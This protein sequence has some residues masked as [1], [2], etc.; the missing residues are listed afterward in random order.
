[1][2]SKLFYYVVLL[3]MI[4][5]LPVFS[6][7]SNAQLVA[8]WSLDG[9][10]LDFS[11]NGN[12][13]SGSNGS[14]VTGRYGFSYS[15][16]GSNSLIMVPDSS[17]LSAPGNLTI[18]AW[19]FVDGPPTPSNNYNVIVSKWGPGGTSDDE[20]FFIV[21]GDTDGHKL[22]AGINGSGGNLFEMSNIIVP[23]GEWKFVA[24][25]LDTST[26][27]LS[28][29]MGD[30]SGITDSYSV[31]TPV[32]ADYD[33][34]QPLY[35]GFLDAS[36]SHPD[37]YFRGK[38]DEVR[39]YNGALSLTELSKIAQQ[40][41]D[42]K[43]IWSQ[44]A[45]MNVS[46]SG[47]G[48]GV[49][50]GKIYVIGGGDGVCSFSSKNEMYDP[51]TDTWTTKAPMPTP[52]EHL[53]AVV[54]NGKIYAI[55]GV[56][57]CWYGQVTT[58]EEY[59]PTTNSWTTKAPMNVARG[60]FG[61]AA[62]GDTIYVMGGNSG[63]G[64]EL[65][66]AEK[67][68]TLTNTW[69]SIKNL[70]HPTHGKAVSVN[71]YIYF[72]GYDG[73]VQRYDPST[74]T[75]SNMATNPIPRQVFAITTIGNLVYLL[76]GS[77]NNNT[78]STE[79]IAVYDTASD[80]WLN[81][82][83]PI[84]PW[85]IATVNCVATYLNNKIYLIGGG[86]FGG[87]YY[88]LNQVGDIPLP[89]NG[90]FYEN[91]ADWTEMGNPG[92]AGTRTVSILSSDPPH[93][94]VLEIKSTGAGGCGGWNGVEQ[95]LSINTSNYETITL[96]A[97]VKS[98][99]STVANG[100][101]FEGIEAPVTIDLEYL[102]Q[103]NQ[104]KHL[105]FLFSHAGGSCLNPDPYNNWPDRTFIPINVTQNEWYDYLSDNIKTLVPDASIITKITLLGGGWDYEGRVDN[106]ELLLSPT[107]SQIPTAIELS[108]FKAKQRGKKVVIKWETASE[109]DNLGFNILRS[110]SENGE[111]VKINK[112]FIPAKK[113]ASS[114]TKYKFKDKNISKG[115]TY[116]YKL[117]DIDTAGNSTLHE[118]VSVKVKGKAFKK[119]HHKK[120]KK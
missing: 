29:Y 114:G 110:N 14:Y 102:T 43:I 48:I 113:N 26:H 76:A 17:S 30:S 20:Y 51:A 21:T 47:P 93:T 71:G 66:S 84:A 60:T 61:A 92:C 63:S 69:S 52:R 22:A 91:F 23:Y 3:F 75:W 97:S 68:D 99:S 56:N 107:S 65:S 100:C 70:N 58:V 105:I 27:T 96:K 116:W 72:F 80:S 67:Y 18:S 24:M 95:P 89:V 73:T 109:V 25:T 103:S 28:M 64:S 41:Q 2:K 90:D 37:H 5:S 35:M 59:D 85:Y 7:I 40:S 32:I 117:E 81:E 115:N 42:G 83:Y 120:H 1:M 62:I 86:P 15:F 88:G 34:A 106:V 53:S 82:I 57:S 111:F 108:S 45:A 38:I 50:D 104:Q 54:V 77:I 13:G 39:I 11:G 46:R 79:T 12:S 74:D 55:G 19:I 31:S 10:A 44:K 87:G 16:N 4:L 8:Y 94:N 78:A 119:K 6:S 118:P 33:T 36:S 112:K 98:I 101:G 49:V 9:N